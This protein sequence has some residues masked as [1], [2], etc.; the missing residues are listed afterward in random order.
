MKR[1]LLIIV[2]AVIL[3][4]LAIIGYQLA[5]DPG[6]EQ[7][8]V[9]SADPNQQ[10]ARGEYLARAGNCMGCHTAR[11]GESYA[12]GRQIATPFGNIYTSNITP[13]KETGIGSWTADDFWRAI[14]NGKSKDGKFLYPA[15]PYPNYTKVSR[16]DADAMFAYLRTVAPVKQANKDHELRFPYNQRVLLAFWR[17]LYFTPGEF[18]A[19]ANQSTEWNRGA[20][21]VQGLGHCA[22]CHTSRNALGGTTA[23]GD[24]A[25]GMIPMQNWYAS[26]LTSGKETGLGEWSEQ[27]IASLLKTGVS[28]RGAVFGPMAEVV[29]SSLQHLSDSDIQSMSIYLKSLPE[30]DAGIE[31]GRMKITGDVEA[32]LKQGAAI[33]ENHCVNCHQANGKGMPPAYPP[34]AANRSLSASAATNTIRMILN[35]GYPPSTGGNPRPYGMPPFSM[36]LSDQEIAAVASYIRMSWGNKGSL[37]SSVEVGRFRGAPVE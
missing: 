10:V 20:Y 9:A 1:I 36:T 21:L 32:V 8:S 15:F 25:G 19:Q 22:A 26:S 17:T 28:H 29:A 13:D 12:G 2:A 23:E 14:H 3:I 16:N 5:H 34:L 6:S 24:L 7:R 4:P 18:E 31:T 37:V 33:Y 35:G 27:E 11:G 30:R